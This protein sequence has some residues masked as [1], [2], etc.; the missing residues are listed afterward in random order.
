MSASLG[1]YR[2]QQVDRQIDRTQSQLEVIRKTLEN[3]VELR[4]ALSRVE[5]AKKEKYQTY[6]ALKLAET[7]AQ[8]QQIKIQQAESSLYGGTVHNPKELQDLQQDVVS[9][10]RHLATLE[11]REL[12]VMMQVEQVEAVLQTSQMELE[13]LQSRLGNEHQKLLENKDAMLNDLERFT[14]EREAALAPIESRLLETYEYLRQQR[15]GLAV[16]EVSD[17]SCSACGSRISAALQQN[18]RSTA[19]LAH[20]PTCGRIIFAG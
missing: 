18:A 6:H 1:L 9:L 17:N 11:D 13:R 3:D 12:E 5:A 10:K 14:E 8:N 16:A 19:Q 20:C 15:R 2:L 7:E 4:E